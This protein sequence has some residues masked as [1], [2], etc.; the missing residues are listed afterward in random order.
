MARVFEHHGGGPRPLVLFAERDRFE[1]KAWNRVRHLVA[2]RLHRPQANGTAVI[3]AA[4]YLVR[5]SR[6]YQDAAAALRN[7]ATVKAYLWCQLAAVIAHEAAHTAPMT[8]RAALLSEAG[9]LRRCLS[10]GHLHSS[11]GWSAGAYLM[12]VE[13]RLRNPQEHY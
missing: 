4:I 8:E 7:G 2:F 1:R 13:A 10:A 12:Q 9:Q 3:D 6:L 5:A 11:D